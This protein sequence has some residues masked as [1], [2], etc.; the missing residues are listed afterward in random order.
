[1]SIEQNAQAI[2][3][4]CQAGPIPGG[5]S[6]N[7][8]EQAQAIIDALEWISVTERL[9][10]LNKRVMTKHLDGTITMNTYASLDS[11]NRWIN[12][13]LDVIAWREVV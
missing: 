9:P 3:D 7:I 1:M 5:I 13:M 10:E 12:G 4:I 11:G 8:K 2:L 6:I